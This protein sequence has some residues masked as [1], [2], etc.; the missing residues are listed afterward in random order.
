MFTSC[1]PLLLFGRSQ[2][3]L[4]VKPWEAGADLKALFE[5]I[6]KVKSLPFYVIDAA[7]TLRCKR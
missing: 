7:Y 6:R 5:K 1:S 2:V 4:E 3:V